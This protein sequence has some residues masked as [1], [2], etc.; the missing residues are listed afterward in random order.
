MLL[1]RC[2]TCVNYEEIKKDLQ[3]VTKIKPFKINELGR[4]KFSIRKR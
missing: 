1:I 2:N 3:R 4:N